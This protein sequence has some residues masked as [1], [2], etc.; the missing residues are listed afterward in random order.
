MCSVDLGRKTKVGARLS[1]NQICVALI[2]GSSQNLASRKYAA[3][4]SYLDG[5]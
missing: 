1:A 2:A 3:A 4:I 5:S